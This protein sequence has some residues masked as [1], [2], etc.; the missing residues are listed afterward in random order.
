M[1]LLACAFWI[2]AVAGCSIPV[3]SALLGAGLSFLPLENS[4]GVVSGKK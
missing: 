3:Y 2:K 4:C 1:A